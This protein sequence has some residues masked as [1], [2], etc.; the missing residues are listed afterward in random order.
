MRE[1]V[2]LGGTSALGAALGIAA[3]TVARRIPYAHHP[4]LRLPARGL[5]LRSEPAALVGA[6]VPVAAW[7]FTSSFAA[8]ITCSAIGWL[9]LAIAICD[10][11]TLCIPH[12]LWIVGAA[13]G[14]AAAW[15]SGSSAG[16]AARVTGVGLLEAT[17]FSASAVA[18]LVRRRAPVGSA[19]YGVLAFLG[20]V[21][22]PAVTA[23]ILL[24]GAV[25]AL[26]VVACATA[27]AS[28]RART[29]A[30][31]AAA[32]GAS[33]A[34]G[35]PGAVIGAAGLAVPIALAARR[36]RVPGPAP[37]GACL[38]AAAICVTLASGISPE[39]RPAARTDLLLQHLSTG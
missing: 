8:A 7:M 16:L 36:G 32:V 27:P 28:G 37:F 20:A 2:L 23:E 6:V 33:L 5:F 17:L 26:G 25:I 15:S 34:G 35:L 24:L 13:T 4:H 11:R 29:A 31:G 10:E 21:F 9:L 18:W 19:D 38:A 14:F 12:V 3:A 30:L 39:L 22:G 1:A